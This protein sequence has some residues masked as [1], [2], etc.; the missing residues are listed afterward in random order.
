[1]KNNDDVNK[2]S[3]AANS[4]QIGQNFIEYF[5][6]IGLDETDLQNPFLYT[7]SANEL[8]NAFKPSI[9]NKFPT[10]MKKDIDIPDSIVNVS[11]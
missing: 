1:M 7:A 9:Y 4:I 5:F 8:T 10:K 6:T 3:D 2:E 11:F